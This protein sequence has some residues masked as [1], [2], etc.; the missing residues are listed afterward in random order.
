M[1]QATV[2][3]LIDRKHLLLQRKTAGLLGE[4][5]WNGVGSKLKVEEAPIGGTIR[6][7]WEETK[8]QMSI[9]KQHGILSFYFGQRS[10]LDWIVYV[11][12]TDTFEGVLKASE[13]GILRWFTFDTVP[14]ED[15]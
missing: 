12:S 1:V 5:K 2:C 7:V 6:E 14:Y 3:H 11:C 15:M 4:G 10:N 13:E 9:L 8:L